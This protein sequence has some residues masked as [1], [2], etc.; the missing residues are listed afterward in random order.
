MTRD[1]NFENKKNRAI[2]IMVR[3]GMWRSNYAP[4]CHIFLWK[5]GVRV[6]PPPFSRFRTNFFCYAGIY[7]PFWGMVMWFVLWKDQ[8]GGVVHAFTTALTIGL[9]FGIIMAAFEYLIKRVHGLPEWNL[10]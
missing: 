10:V 6:P 4:P 8:G 9:L 5:L 3:K 1:A 7:T 2:A